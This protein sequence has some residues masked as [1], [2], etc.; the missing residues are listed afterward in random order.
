M[1]DWVVDYLS[2]LAPEKQIIKEENT[3]LGEKPRV[4]FL[5]GTLRDDDTIRVNDRSPWLQY[6]LEESELPAVCSDSQVMLEALDELLTTKGLK[7][8]RIDSKTVPEPYVK[9]C[10]LNCDKYIEANRPDV[11]L[12]SPA[13]ESG[14]DVSISDHFTH[15]FC[16]F[17]GVIDI[18][19]ISQMMGRLRAN[20]VK[21]VWCKSFVVDDERQDSG[22]PFTNQIVKSINQTLI[23]D[24][25]TSL[26]KDDWL[27]R[28]TQHLKEVIANSL[29]QDLR[30]SCIIKAT[31][32]FEKSNLRECLREV[33]VESGYKVVNCKLEYD[34]YSKKKVSKATEAVKRQ[35]CADIFNAEKID[36][37]LVDEL[38]FDSS[39][40]ERCEVI[41]AKLRERLPG[42]EDSEVWTEDF[43]YLIRYDDRNFV[44]NIENYWLF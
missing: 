39:W 10:L 15:H 35:N 4:N 28:V 42:I 34:E 29:N 30:T 40:Q 23:D 37:E 44:N 13:A 3:Y 41:Q 11:L 17:F 38:K 5:L 16:F 20:I 24:I 36:P 6:L 22:S 32:N 12:Y 1:T 21:F 33:L 2:S 25:S 26:D 19:G 43:I 14:V 18:D 9:E 31:Q 7:V 27:E 8:L